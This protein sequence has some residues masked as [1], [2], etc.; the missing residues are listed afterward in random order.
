MDIQGRVPTIDKS[1][2][3]VVFAMIDLD[4]AYCYWLTLVSAIP[5]IDITYLDHDT[6]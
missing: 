6:D 3:S 1:F 4:W 5:V 2:L